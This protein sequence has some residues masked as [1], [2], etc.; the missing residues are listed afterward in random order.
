MKRIRTSFTGV[1]GAPYLSTM[2]FGD[3]STAQ[4]CVDH[5][6]DF[7]GVMADLIVTDCAYSVDPFVATV[8]PITGEITGAETVTGSNGQGTAGG[9]MMAP[10]DQILVRWG[11]GSYI[12]GRELRGRTFIPALTQS[13][14]ADGVVEPTTL[15]GHTTDLETWLGAGPPLLLWS[16]ANAET[17]VAASVVIW[18]QFAVLRSRRD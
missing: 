2:F 17:R 14:N 4:D 8:D 1:A 12:G 7:W 11:S 9:E 5:V 10:A 6:S 3:S 18:N 13:A 15:P 16:R